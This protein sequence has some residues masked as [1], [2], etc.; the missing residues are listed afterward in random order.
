MEGLLEGLVDDH[1]FLDNMFD[2]M[3]RPEGTSVFRRT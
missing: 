1:E 2:L 3:V